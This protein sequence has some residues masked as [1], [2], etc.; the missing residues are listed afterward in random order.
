MNLFSDDTV[1]LGS[2]YSP[3]CR[4]DSE[5]LE[6]AFDTLRYEHDFKTLGVPSV[7][8]HGLHLVTRSTVSGSASS[9]GTSTY[10]PAQTSSHQPVP[11]TSRD[12]PRS[13]QGSQE[14]GD[15]D[16]DGSDSGSGYNGGAGGMGKSER[17]RL[18]TFTESA[19]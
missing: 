7:V 19:A 1:P 3:F 12:N 5:K 10:I 15:G 14:Y 13:H 4:S 9:S 11:V 6:R 16:D 2:Y 8:N 18:C 17:N